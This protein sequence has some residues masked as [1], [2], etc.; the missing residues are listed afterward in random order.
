MVGEQVLEGL[1]FALF[2]SFDWVYLEETVVFG[3]TMIEG[4]LLLVLLLQEDCGHVMFGIDS[5]IL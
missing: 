3:A 5:E 1:A 2:G 4:H